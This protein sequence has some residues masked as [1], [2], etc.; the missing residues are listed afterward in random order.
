MDETIVQK[1]LAEIEQLKAEVKKAQRGE[2]YRQIMNLM[3]AHTFCYNAHEQQY[4][5]DNF[6]TKT[7]QDSFYNSNTGP[8]GVETYYVNNTRMLRDKQREIINRV[9]GKNLTEADK[10]GYRVIHLLGTPYI[11]I[12]GDG[13]TAQGVWMTFNV[14]CHVDE[15][16]I[17]QPTVNVGKQC[18]EFCKDDGEWKLWRFRGCPGGFDLKVELANTGLDPAEVEE[19]RRKMA[20]GTPHFTPEQEAL[21]NKRKLVSDFGPLMGYQPWQPT[22]NDP[23]LPKPYETW[24]D[25]TPFFIFA[26]EEEGK[27][28][29]AAAAETR[30]ELDD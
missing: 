5:I 14:M 3:S 11:E 27:R 9:Y 24:E 30:P 12:A 6:W 8:V 15:D 21:L 1:L 16:G 18:A 22:V 13:Q 2:D 23:P 25:T 7:R 29:T 4:E 19:G 10:V 26:D 20:F 28:R 17:P